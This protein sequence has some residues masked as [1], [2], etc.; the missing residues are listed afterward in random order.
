MFRKKRRA[1]QQA[2]E[3]WQWIADKHGRNRKPC[4]HPT[5][6]RGHAAT[7]TDYAKP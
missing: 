6:P 7:T 3:A 5:P 1:D 2:W 4:G